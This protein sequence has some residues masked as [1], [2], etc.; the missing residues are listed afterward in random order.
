[1]SQQDVELVRSLGIA[2]GVD[3]AAIVRDDMLSAALEDAVRDR[4]DPSFDV[5][6]VAVT[7]TWRTGFAGLRQVWLDW[8]EPWS[9]YRV[10][11][12]D[13]I[14]L[15]GGRVLYLGRDFGTRHETPG[16]VELHASAIWTVRDGWVVQ[17][18]FYADRA[19]ALAAAGLP[20]DGPRA[21]HAGR[22]ESARAGAIRRCYEQHNAGDQTGWIDL[23]DENLEFSTQGTRFAEE[24][25]LRGKEAVVAWFVDYFESFRDYEFVVEDIREIGDWIV[26]VVP[27]RAVGR[28]SGI[29]VGQF[30]VGCFRFTGEKVVEF[31]TFGT[32]DAALETVGTAGSSAR[33]D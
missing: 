5:A 12:E 23:F 8:L 32:L 11:E 26:A 7:E 16:E 2:P 17:I 1:M 24:T 19:V 31:R 21:P 3:W 22:P 15:G 14:D 18:V 13:V 4:I 27:V 30:G 20:S 10:Q 33:S 25:S 28:T 9:T 6:M 29:E